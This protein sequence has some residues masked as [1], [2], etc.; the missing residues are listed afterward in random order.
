MECG[1]QFVTISLINVLLMLL[2]VNWD[3]RDMNAS[4]ADMKA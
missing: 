2:V 3:F 4:V 1:E